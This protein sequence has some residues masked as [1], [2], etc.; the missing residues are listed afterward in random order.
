MARSAVT[1]QSLSARNTAATVTKDVIDA[2]NNHSISVDAVKTSNLTIFIETSTTD[3]MTFA[4]KAGDFTDNGIG[5]L[6]I[7]TVTALTQVVVLESARFKDDDELILIDV[8]GTGP[9]FIYAVETP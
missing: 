9:G 8:T 2:T 7:T 1:V 5:D 6:T 4:I 3:P